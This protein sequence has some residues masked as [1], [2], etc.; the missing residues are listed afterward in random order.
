MYKTEGLGALYAGLVPNYTKIFP[1]A[2]VSFYVYEAL[3]L[4]YG[5]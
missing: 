1:A 2:A 3:K 4:H 5:L